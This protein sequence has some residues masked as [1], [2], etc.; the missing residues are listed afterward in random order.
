MSLPRA[1]LPRR[2]ARWLVPLSLLA[3]APKCVLCVIAYAGLGAA[4]GAGGAELCGAVAAPSVSVASLATPLAWFGLAGG[5]GAA[6]I[7]ARA[8]VAK[9]SRG[10]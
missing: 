1:K 7:L 5:V 6:G 8:R 2:A 10:R 3:L 4:L 9:C